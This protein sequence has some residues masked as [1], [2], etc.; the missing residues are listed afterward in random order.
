MHS[1]ITLLARPATISLLAALA[2]TA[3]AAAQGCGPDKPADAPTGTSGAT[4][5]ATAP[6][7]APSAASATTATAPVGDP[8]AKARMDALK[9]SPLATPVANAGKD[10]MWARALVDTAAGLGIAPDGPYYKAT[11][12]EKGIAHTDVTL[13]AGKCYVIVGFAKLATIID[14][15]LALLKTT[16]EKVSEDDDDDATPVL[17]K[18]PI[19]PTED[20]VYA[21]EM[22]ADKGAGDAVVQLFSKAK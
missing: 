21:I 18:P 16:G 20:T 13:K 10:D 15:D 8:A 5:A 1:R 22:K 9:A 3:A 6:S 2:L 14:Y 7:A 17:S 4:S 11:L 12:T 19:C